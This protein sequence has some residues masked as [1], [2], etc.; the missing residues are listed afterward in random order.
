MI[1]PSTARLTIGSAAA[2]SSAHSRLSCLPKLNIPRQTRETRSPVRPRFTYSIESLAL[3]LRAHLCLVRALL[4]LVLGECLGRIDV[5]ERRMLGH[6]LVHSLELKVE[7]LREH[8][9][10][11]AYLHFA[12][13]WKGREPRLQILAVAR[14]RPHALGVAVVLIR[15]HAREIL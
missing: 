1:P 15:D 10:H 12:E 6:D 5:A 9:Q 11:R 13:A 14:L 3:L 2:S 4:C 7:A 8:P